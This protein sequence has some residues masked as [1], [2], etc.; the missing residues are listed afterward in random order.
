MFRHIELCEGL[1]AHLGATLTFW[2]WR[3]RRGAY[4]RRSSRSREQRHRCLCNVKM[5]RRR[6]RS[7]RILACSRGTW[8]T[9]LCTARVFVQKKVFSCLLNREII[10]F[11][12]IF[13]YSKQSRETIFVFKRKKSFSIFR[14]SFVNKLS[15]Y[16][17]SSLSCMSTKS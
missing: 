6:R 14:P 7:I 12:Y 8:S 4:D 2:R 9:L 13:Y 11:N 10:T 15:K 1:R 16:A 5:R 17:S 3:R